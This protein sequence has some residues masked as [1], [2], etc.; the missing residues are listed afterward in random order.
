MLKVVKAHRKEKKKEVGLFLLSLKF[1]SFP[2]QCSFTFNE[3]CVDG[4][5]SPIDSIISRLRSMD[6]STI[7]SLIK[8]YTLENAPGKSFPLDLLYAMWNDVSAVMQA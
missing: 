8:E 5:T 4:P 1:F 6:S 2:S 3:C 7:I